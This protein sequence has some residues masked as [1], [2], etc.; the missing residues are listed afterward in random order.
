MTEIRKGYCPGCPFDYGKEATETAYN[1]GCLPSIG[2]I[3]EHCGETHSW[4]CHSDS[5]LV[6]SGDA[7]NRDKPLKIME[8]IHND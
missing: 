8:G 2:E 3:R 6:C 7:V 5:S 4:P 1:L